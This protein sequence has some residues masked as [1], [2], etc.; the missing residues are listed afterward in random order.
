M[1]TIAK[2]TK[3]SDATS[4]YARDNYYTKNDGVEHSWW[5]GEGAKELGL[6]GAVDPDVFQ[7]L[8]TGKINDQTQLGRVTQAGIQHRPGWD[9]TFSAPKSISILSEIYGVDLLREAHESAVKD[10]LTHSEKHFSRARIKQGESVEFV[11]TGNTI[12]AAFTH[13]VSREQEPQLHTHTILIN[14]TKT[15][16]G[17]RS[18]S[19]E[20]FFK[21]QK[22]FSRVYKN[23]LMRRTR[24]LGFALR[25][26][27][28]DPSLFEIDGVSDEIIDVFSTR[29]KQIRETLAAQNIDYDATA[30]KKASLVTRRKKEFLSREELRHRWL[31]QVDNY[32]SPTP[33]L[34]IDVAQRVNALQNVE[35]STITL[36]AS[37]FNEQPDY[38]TTAYQ[39]EASSKQVK[40]VVFE[41]VGTIEDAI[42][43]IADKCMRSADSVVVVKNDHEQKLLNSAIR[44]TLVE[45]KLLGENEILLPIFQKIYLSADQKR[46]IHFYKNGD[47]VFIND[48]RFYVVGVNKSENK[49]VIKNDEGKLTNLSVNEISK[50]S[51][52]YRKNELA[53]RV[54]EKIRFQKSIPPYEIPANAIGRITAISAD[55]IILTV[56]G[57][58]IAVNKSELNFFTYNYIR[59]KTPEQS[60]KEIIKLV[61]RDEPIRDVINSLRNKGVTQR[62]IST[63]DTREK[64]EHLYNR[65][66]QLYAVRA[67]RLGIRHIRERELAMS[68]EQILSAAKT[69]NR[70]G[71]IDN[72]L[73]NEI[74]RLKKTGYIFSAPA[75]PDKPDVPLWTTEKAVT[76]EVALTELLHA[77]R[78][79]EKS[80]LTS[81]EVKFGLRNTSLNEQQKQAVERALTSS[82]RFFAIQGD[83]GVGKTTTLNA[84]KTL[85]VRNNYTVLGF[86]PSHQ[87]VAELSKSLKMPGFT[88]DRFLVDTKV[89]QSAVK[90]RRNLWVVDESSMLSIDRIER[91]MKMAETM[92]AKV[93]LVGDHK[94]LESV[95]AGQAFKI[96][97]DAGID[98]SVID[99]RLRQKT[100]VTQRVTELIMEKNYSSALDALSVQGAM[101]KSRD[102]S[103]AIKSMVAEWGKLAPS[104]RDETLLVAPANEQ[105]EEIDALVRDRLRREGSLD[106]TEKEY[107]FLHDKYLTEQ[108]KRFAE[109]Y[110]SGDV[111]RF[112][113][114]YDQVEGVRQGK[115]RRDDYFRVIGVNKSSGTLVIESVLDN[116]KRAHIDPRQIGADIEGA[117][118]VYKE[119]KKAIAI[120]DRVRWVDSRGNLGI[121]KN[122]EGVVTGIGNDYIRFK[123]NDKSVKLNTAEWRHRHLEYAYSKTAFAVQGQ[124]CKRVFALMEHWRK[125]TVNQRSLMVALTRASHEM[126]IFT[127]SDSVQL[128]GALDERTATKTR[129]HKL[130]D[131]IMARSLI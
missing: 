106:K 93:L 125:N 99:K 24:A 19:P 42:R 60:K 16:D 124:T 41:S 95:G 127:S 75:H 36:P 83:P 87:A 103:D 4:Y 10:A 84:L 50:L 3:A 118:T 31:T 39:P 18:L 109:C 80:I 79:I 98:H 68:D 126:K 86:A 122:T 14:A 102:E 28:H 85:A 128:A 64:I 130:G 81:G 119:D 15:A 13:D 77:N 47:M 20:L 112:N 74:D 114:N 82:S 58:E 120:G 48:Q 97:L 92:N 110:S 34:S 94:Q 30:A 40:D 37:V 8:L 107:T 21:Q 56:K 35:S 57:K 76:R 26:S 96:L 12:V 67:V 62:V 46:D 129:A 61:S 49:L 123:V 17:W 116:K 90:G 25:P 121:S 1:L 117:M 32:Q 63:H 59:R 23:S 115:I 2:L 51:E 89:Q 22:Q 45:N 7:A 53:L 73:E 100:E 69:F 113:K 11:A 70:H 88:V 52:I 72:V 101:S 78:D 44:R 6:Q 54:G 55:Q 104:E 33:A 111:I 43:F 71:V 66:E 65:R 38:S 27:R 91:M 131:K 29:S 5:Q 105:R 108:Q 9:F